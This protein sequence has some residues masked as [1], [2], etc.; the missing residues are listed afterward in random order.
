MPSYLV[1]AHQTAQSSQLMQAL[2]EKLQGEPGTDI[3]LLVP[4]TPYED[5]RRS[6][7]GSLRDIARRAAGDAAVAIKS[8]GIELRWT[9]ISEYTPAIALAAELSDHPGQYVGV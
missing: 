6:Q 9:V 7:T 2:K 1:I 3:V 8:A 4:V 5:L